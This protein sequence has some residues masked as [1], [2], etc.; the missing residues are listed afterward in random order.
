MRYCCFSANALVQTG[1]HRGSGRKTYGYSLFVDL[2]GQVIFDA[3]Q[4]PGLHFV[5]LDLT[6]VDKVRERM[7]SLSHDR[8][9]EVRYHTNH[10][11]PN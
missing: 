2:W 9:F 5:E 7:A 11:K 8:N 3:G 1:V 10:D 6:D 4:L